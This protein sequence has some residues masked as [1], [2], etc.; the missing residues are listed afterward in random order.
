V[1]TANAQIAASVE[2]SVLLQA[3]VDELRDQLAEVEPELL[4]NM[5]REGVDT[6]YGHVDAAGGRTYKWDKAAANS[7]IAEHIADT[8]GIHQKDVDAVIKELNSAVSVSGYRAQGL[9]AVGIDS[10]SVASEVTQGDR[11]G[12][13]EAVD[14]PVTTPPP[15]DWQEK[16]KS[17]STKEAAKAYAHATGY[18]NYLAGKQKAATA[19]AF[20][21]M[22]KTPGASDT[23]STPHGDFAISR[24]AHRR[25]WDREATLEATIPS[26]AKNA[27]VSEDQARNIVY[28]YAEVASIS[29]GK[30]TFFKKNGLDQ[31][32]VSSMVDPAPQVKEQ[33]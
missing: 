31:E 25:K 30:S 1:D 26:I 32:K 3:Q 20:D 14:S 23:V 18:K 8:D 24:G 28:R 11:R 17:G 5:P 7:A 10:A 27:G 29:G 16:V 21:T 13:V 4:K 6:L 19:A 15:A 33:V 22:S 2:A 12:T 9:R